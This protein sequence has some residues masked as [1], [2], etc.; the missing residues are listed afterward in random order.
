V[1]AILLVLAGCGATTGTSSP[2]RECSAVISSL[3]ERSSTFVRE[4]L[5]DRQPQLTDVIARLTPAVVQS[6]RDDHWSGELLACMDGLQVT[7]DPHKCNHLFT[8]DQ[9]VGVAKRVMVVVG[10]WT[11]DVCD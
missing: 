4:V 10:Q 5:G 1:R 11:R 8:H 9:A 6:C 7:D 3:F 2:H